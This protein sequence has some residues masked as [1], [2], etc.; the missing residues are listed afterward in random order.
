MKVFDGREVSRD[1]GNSDIDP[2]ALG[3]LAK[4]RCLRDSWVKDT[5]LGD[6]LRLDQPDDP[7]A[8]TAPAPS[9]GWGS[10]RPGT[11]VPDP[12]VG[13]PPTSAEEARAQILANSPRFPP[14]RWDPLQAPVQVYFW[15]PFDG[16]WTRVGDANGNARAKA[17]VL[18]MIVN[19]RFPVT[20]CLL[21][22]SRGNEV[23]RAVKNAGTEPSGGDHFGNWRTIGSGVSRMWSPQY[24]FYAR[25]F[26]PGEAMR[27]DLGREADGETGA[28]T[29]TYT[30]EEGESPQGVAKR[31]DALSRR[32][33]AAELK[34]ANPERDWT[35]RLYAGDV[36]TI[37]DAWP[38]PFWGAAKER[39]F[40]DASGPTG[41]LAV[42]TADPFL[43]LRAQRAR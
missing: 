33:W 10:P 22:T 24:T 14:T 8:P 7:F 40:L 31:Y 32:R 25:T 11:L 20:Y 17:L 36:L 6:F 18:M 9:A 4:R 28:V 2:S 19:Y 38:A 27:F 16:E 5:W 21:H 12:D 34:A 30:A 26:G 15:D 43:D 37:P 29:R 39:G 23:M 42:D 1:S 35:A 41:E 13:V 3:E